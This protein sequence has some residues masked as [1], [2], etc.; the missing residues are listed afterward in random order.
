[1]P[2]GPSE[3]SG[4]RAEPARIAP[5][6]PE[7]APRRDVPRPVVKADLLPAVSTLSL[8]A[9]LGLPLGWA[10]SR[11]APPKQTAV[12]G[13]GHLSSVLV[14]SYHE[15]DALG[16]FLLLSFGVGVVTAVALWMRRSRRGPVFLLAGVFGSALAAW[17]GTALGT[18]FAQALYPVGNP[19]AGGGLVTVP[20]E[21]A[22]PWVI[23]AQ[24]F[25]VALVYGLAAS[26]NGF[27]DLGRRRAG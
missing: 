18:G 26:W 12:T 11:L 14:E 9:L 2:E 24:P 8:I 4:A 21:V 22:T 1:M 13:D 15:F 7:D 17:L 19:P 23:L 27:D 16:V 25:A 20:P 10:W 6:G 3:S 5:A